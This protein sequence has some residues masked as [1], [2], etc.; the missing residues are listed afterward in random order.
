V[1]TPP[2]EVRPDSTA[3]SAQVQARTKEAEGGQENKTMNWGSIINNLAAA[4]LGALMM[5]LWWSLRWKRVEDAAEVLRDMRDMAT[6]RSRT[7]ADP[8]KAAGIYGSATGLHFA[9]KVLT[10]HV[11]RGHSIGK[12]T[13]ELEAPPDPSK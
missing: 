13:D 8:V 6:A 11:C 9:A 10:R 12:I 5:H 3:S 7:E 1:G 4:A 2:A